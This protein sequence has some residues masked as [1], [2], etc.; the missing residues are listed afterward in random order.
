MNSLS[1]PSLHSFGHVALAGGVIFTT[2]FLTRSRR[3]SFP[4]AELGGRRLRF[5]RGVLRW[6]IIGGIT[7]A[8]L[9]ALGVDLKGLWSALAATLSLIAIGFVAMWSIL[10]HM[11]ASL[12]IVIFRPFGVGDRIEVVGDDSVIGEVLDLNPVYTLLR[13]DDGGVVQV[14]NNV[15]FQ[16]AVKRHVSTP[17]TTPEPSSDLGVI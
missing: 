17:P 14:P 5:P 11:L 15:F 13:S 9:L 16:K 1:L 7:V 8:T 3:A 6:I 2:A 4:G 12:L 10:S